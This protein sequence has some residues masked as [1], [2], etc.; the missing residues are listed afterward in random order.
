M[1]KRTFQK[2]VAPA[3]TEMVEVAAKYETRTYKKFNNGTTTSTDVAPQY[4]NVKIEK[5]S[6]PATAN[7]VDVAAQYTSRTY[8]KLIADATTNTIPAAG[9]NTFETVT[10]RKLVS[11]A[12]IKKTDLAAEY[13]TITKKKLLKAGGF[14]E[15]KEVVCDADVTTD[16]IRRVQ[17]ALKDRGYDI[18]PA[19]TDN[20]MG[21]DTKA[22]LIKYQKENSLPIGSL[23]L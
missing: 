2:L 12:T 4:A 3:T 6:A 15:W 16:L 11:P 19:G 18:G 23:E 13:T 1:G 21:A 9:S 17:K 8:E 5:V 22:A 20:I 7:T 10:Y 14:S